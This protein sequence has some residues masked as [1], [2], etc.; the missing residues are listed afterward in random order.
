MSKDIVVRS[1][2]AEIVSGWRW[3]TRRRV[4][5]GFVALIDVM[6]EACVRVVPRTRAYD[7]LVAL[8][9]LVHMAT[10]G[11]YAVLRR[12]SPKR[13]FRALILRDMLCAATGADG[14]PIHTRVLGGDALE[15]VHA[16][17]GR[18]ILCTVH[19]GLTLAVFSAIEACGIAPAGLGL[20]TGKRDRFAW[21]CTKPVLLI[22][23][24]AMGLLRAR[25]ALDQGHA[26]VVFPEMARSRAELPD[27]GDPAFDIAP[28]V[29]T[30]ARLTKTPVLFF[31]SA[32]DPDGAI[33]LEFLEPVHSVPRSPEDEAALID[34]FCRFVEVRTGRPCS[35]LPPRRRNP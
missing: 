31:S 33:R 12:N 9:A 16:A 34:D 30:F 4:E 3:R 6:A 29:F 19:F 11:V 13:D 17:H 7:A 5:R 15:R 35:P 1:L 18:V 14:F 25:A 22:E 8:S 26:L 23:S 32:L 24:D 21:G 27:S 20:V 28:N 10:K 2:P